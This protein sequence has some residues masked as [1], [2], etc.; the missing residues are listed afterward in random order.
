MSV[1]EL[2]LCRCMCVYICRS[3]VEPSGFRVPGVVGALGDIA[4]LSVRRKTLS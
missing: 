1:S 3:I 4:S 2:K